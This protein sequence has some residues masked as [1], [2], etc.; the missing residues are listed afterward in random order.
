MNKRFIKLINN[1]R[2]NF[3]IL[4]EKAYVNTCAAGSLDVCDSKDFATCTVNSVDVCVKDYA[5]CTNN[6]F[7]YCGGGGL[8]YQACYQGNT[9]TL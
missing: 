9:D 1:E 7:D 2:A 6:S 4:S 3:K 5:G 8:D